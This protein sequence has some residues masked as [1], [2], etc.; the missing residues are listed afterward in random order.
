MAKKETRMTRQI[1]VYDETA[2]LIDEIVREN[3]GTT[4]A[5]VVED[6]FRQIYPAAYG[7]ITKSSEEVK[8]ALR[9]DRKNA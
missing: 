2:R 4:F 5:Q 3:P 9:K 6:V 8:A 7:V 1:R